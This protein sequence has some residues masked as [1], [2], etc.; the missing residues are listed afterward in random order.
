MG[1][2]VSYFKQILD[3]EVVIKDKEYKR[4]IKQ[5]LESPEDLEDFIFQG[6]KFTC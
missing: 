6:Q 5:D 4:L 2:V 1:L 3:M